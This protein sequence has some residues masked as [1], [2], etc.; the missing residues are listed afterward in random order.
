MKIKVN[1][2]Y[3]TVKVHGSEFEGFWADIVE[4][5]GCF[6]QSKSFLQIEQNITEAIRLNAVRI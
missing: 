5:P 4:L 6:T 1:D 2:R 3:F